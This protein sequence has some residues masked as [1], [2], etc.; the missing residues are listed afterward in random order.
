MGHMIASSLVHA[1]IYGVV[2][3]VT[4]HLS[5]PEDIGLA[6]VVIVGVALFG[7]IMRPGMRRRW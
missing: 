7:R 5:L 1:V 6:V 4:R 3:R 2:W